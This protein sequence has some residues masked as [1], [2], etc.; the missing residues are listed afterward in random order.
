MAY[1]ELEDLRAYLGIETT[2]TTDD[3]LLQSSIEDAEEYIESQTNRR[4]GAFTETR[5]YGRDALDRYDSTVLHL[6]ADL[7]TVTTLTNGDSS[8]T[9]IASTDYSVYRLLAA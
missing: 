3:D 6:D 9:A 5:H 8:S 2:E 4:Y 1:I 7:L